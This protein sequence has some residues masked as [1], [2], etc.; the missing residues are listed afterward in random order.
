MAEFHSLP[1]PSLLALASAGG[2]VPGDLYYC[3]QGK[4]GS[5]ELFLAITGEPNPGLA[6]L[7]NIVLSGNFSLAGSP[8][9]TGATG[10]QGPQGPAGPE[11]SLASQI[12]LSIAL[13]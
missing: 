11:P 6:P 7:G 9:P 1:Y 13:G 10:P 2:C 5:G 8:G 3:P 12:A 4:T